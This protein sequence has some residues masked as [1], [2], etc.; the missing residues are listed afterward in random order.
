MGMHRLFL[1][2]NGKAVPNTKAPTKIPAIYQV[3]VKV[4]SGYFHSHRVDSGKKPV[5][6]RMEHRGQT[7]AFHIRPALNSAPSIA[8]TKN[9]GRRKAIRYCQ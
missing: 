1:L 5:R 9:T 2:V 3:L 7:V 4:V 8:L 6:N